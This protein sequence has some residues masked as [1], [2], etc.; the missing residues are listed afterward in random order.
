MLATLLAGVPPCAIQHAH[1]R[2]VL[3]RDL[4]PGNILLDAGKPPTRRRLRAGAPPRR[5]AQLG[6]HG[7]ALGTPSYMPPEQVRGDKNLTVRADVWARSRAVRTAH[8]GAALPRR[9]R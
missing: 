2:G 3:H 8:R 5:R 7:M 1:D 4:K 6:A 9:L